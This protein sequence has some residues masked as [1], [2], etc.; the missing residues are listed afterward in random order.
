MERRD[1]YQ[2]QEIKIGMKIAETDC[3]GEESKSTNANCSSER[4]GARAFWCQSSVCFLVPNLLYL[5]PGWKGL[6]EQHGC[7]TLLSIPYCQLS[8]SEFLQ[9]GCWMLRETLKASLKPRHRTSIPL[10]SCAELVSQSQVQT[11]L[12]R[13]TSMMLDLSLLFCFCFFCPSYI[14]K[15]FPW[16]QSAIFLRTVRVTNLQLS[17][18]SS[19]PKW[20]WMWQL[21][22]RHHHQSPWPHLVP[23]I[24]A[25]KISSGAS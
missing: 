8:H 16:G 11:Q 3:L 7:D 5:L 25:H 22:F 6:L 2:R 4:W 20:R 15:W 9:C 17:L 24:C 12:D 13:G 23:K 14:W 18:R 1:T 10:H 21:L 19:C